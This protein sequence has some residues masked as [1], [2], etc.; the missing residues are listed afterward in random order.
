VTVAGGNRQGDKLNQLQNPHGLYV[1][2][3]EIIYVADTYNDRIVEWY[4]GA[5]SGQVV[6]GGNGQ[7]KRMDQLNWPTDVIVDKKIGGL[8][9][10][11]RGNERIVRW[12]RQKSMLQEILVTNVA[13]WS[14]TMGD[15]GGL[16]VFDSW[17]DRVRRWYPKPYD[18]RAI[19]ARNIL[20][21]GPSHF[22]FLQELFYDR[23][24]PVY[25]SENG[26]TRIMKWVHNVNKGV[27]V[28]SSQNQVTDLLRMSYPQG[29]VVDK[30]GT[31]YVA[32][33]E[34]HR[35]IRWT[36]EA[37][38]G[39]VIVGGNG[40]RGQPNQL[41]DPYGLSF[42]Q[43]GNLYVVDTGNHRVQRFDIRHNT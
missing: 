1:D 8:L 41:H 24:Q 39:S 19:V 11:D 9:I 35:I 43:F 4:P 29:L 21:D 32:D 27:V 33:K 34:N 10:C 2:D 12:F 18:G 3:N 5:T 42:D 14:I 40:K 30:L 26:S 17:E 22:L 31:I 37:T 36:K 15:R 7:G 25:L 6:A 23:N 13:C 16:Y 28:N 20:E 38:R